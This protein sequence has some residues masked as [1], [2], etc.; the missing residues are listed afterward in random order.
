MKLLFITNDYP[1]PLEPT[2]GVFNHDLVRALSRAND[3]DVVSPVAWTVELSAPRA[4]A[5]AFRAARM[6]DED[7]T[8][9]RYPRYYYPP[10]IMRN[11]YG[12]F[13][14]Q[15]IRGAVQRVVQKDRPDAVLSYWAHPDGAAA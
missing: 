13:Y 2:K 14:W 10:R 12:E 15:S 5:R 9:V 8:R 4:E 11:A 7:G 1:N 3:V 6:K